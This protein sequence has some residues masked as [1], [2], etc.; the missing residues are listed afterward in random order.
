MYVPGPESCNIPGTDLGTGCDTRGRR[1]LRSGNLLQ[2][3]MTADRIVSPDLALRMALALLLT[4]GC[5]YSRRHRA[6]NASTIVFDLIFEASSRIE[7]VVYK[8]QD[9]D[10]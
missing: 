4:L 1:L 7:G 6:T 2:V 8:L 10:W 5:I 9:I 3:A